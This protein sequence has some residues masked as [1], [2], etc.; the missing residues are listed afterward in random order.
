L[1]DDGYAADLYRGLPAGDITRPRSSPTGNATK[2]AGR[3]RAAIQPGS[4]RLELVALLRE[5]G[6]TPVH[7]ASGQPRPYDERAYW[8]RLA[9][10]APTTPTTRAAH[11]AA[12]TAAQR[13]RRR[14]W[15]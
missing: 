14:A 2:A 12:H 7:L 11:T 3:V 13:Q 15:L 8:R 10:G 6:G 5:T 4:A 9:R 1:P